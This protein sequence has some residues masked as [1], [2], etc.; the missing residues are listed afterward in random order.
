MRIEKATTQPRESRRRA[1]P[2]CTA[3]VMLYRDIPAC[4]A[5]AMLY[6]TATLEGV[7]S[8]SCTSCMA[9]YTLGSRIMHMA[10]PSLSGAL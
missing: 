6:N 3:A 5:A 4:T 8:P 7:C 1:L 10:F 9:S 2:A